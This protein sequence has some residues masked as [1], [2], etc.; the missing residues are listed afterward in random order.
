MLCCQKTNPTKPPTNLS[1]SIVFFPSPQ[2]NNNITRNEN[3]A[4]MS[5]ARFSFRV[6]CF[7]YSNRVI[8]KDNV[9]SCCLYSLTDKIKE[10]QMPQFCQ[11]SASTP[12]TNSTSCHLPLYGAMT[13][14]MT[15]LQ[16]TA[17]TMQG[18]VCSKSRQVSDSFKKLHYVYFVIMEWVSIDCT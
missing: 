1:N 16:S 11:D 3:L 2:V 6:S 9:L 18:N 12:T 10:A 14:S 17:P 7:L 5:A 15:T 13:T 4:D 8:L